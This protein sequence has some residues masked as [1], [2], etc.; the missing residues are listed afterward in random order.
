MRKDTL[1]LG[2]ISGSGIGGLS[3]IQKTLQFNIQEVQEKY[4]HSLSLHH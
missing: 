2:I 3:T 1:D 4:L